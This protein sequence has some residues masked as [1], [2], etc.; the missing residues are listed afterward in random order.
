[1]CR[2]L[3]L[4]DVVAVVGR[5]RC[6]PELAADVQQALAD[7]PLDGQPVVHQFEKEIVGT[8]DVAVV[9]GGLQSLFGLA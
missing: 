8:E 4:G 7:R 2:R 9:T 5:Q 3:V 1:M 6:Q